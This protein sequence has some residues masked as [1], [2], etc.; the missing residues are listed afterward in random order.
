MSTK[1]IGMAVFSTK[2]LRV[3]SSYVSAPSHRTLSER[4]LQYPPHA[5]RALAWTCVATSEANGTLARA[6][7]A[8]STTRDLDTH[9]DVR[10]LIL[11]CHVRPCHGWRN[12]S[13]FRTC[14]TNVRLCYLWRY[15]VF[16]NW[17][18]SNTSWYWWREC[19]LLDAVTAGTAFT[20]CTV[21]HRQTTIMSLTIFI[22]VVKNKFVVL[23]LHNY[24]WTVEKNLTQ[25]INKA[26]TR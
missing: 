1:Y 26:T 11:N 17:Q 3:T 25:N 12:H 8:A 5:T 23:N 6:C 18:F 4:A 21:L 9:Y 7:F 2:H 22:R 10:D 19:A 15:A 16:I 13:K 20:F 24:S 14:K